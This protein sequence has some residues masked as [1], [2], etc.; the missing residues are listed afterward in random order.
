MAYPDSPAFE[1]VAAR[2][3][4]A[5]PDQFRGVRLSAYSATTLKAAVPPTFRPFY[6][7]NNP[8]LLKERFDSPWYYDSTYSEAPF[9]S[10]LDPW[11]VWLLQNPIWSKKTSEPST[12]PGPP[13][14]ISDFPGTWR[15]LCLRIDLSNSAYG[16]RRW[17][18]PIAPIDW[19]GAWEGYQKLSL[20]DSSKT[21]K[22]FALTRCALFIIRAR[23]W[24]LRTLTFAIKD[25][26]SVPYNLPAQFSEEL[27]ALLQA[28]RSEYVTENPAYA[29]TSL[30]RHNS[31]DEFLWLTHAGVPL[32]EKVGPAPTVKGIP[33]PKETA[34]APRDEHLRSGTAALG[35]WDMNKPVSGEWGAP[36]SGSNWNVASLPTNAHLA[37][38]NVGIP[39]S[40]SPSQSS[41]AL[42]YPPN[43]PV[44]IR[45]EP[46]NYERKQAAKAA[47]KMNPTQKA[48]K[49][50]KEAKTARRRKLAREIQE[51]RGLNWDQAYDEA[52]ADMLDE[53]L[54]LELERQDSDSEDLPLPLGPARPP[55]PDSPTHHP[56]N[57]VTSPPLPATPLLPSSSSDYPMTNA[58]PITDPIARRDDLLSP[59][60]SPMLG[61]SPTS[62]ARD[63]PASPEALPFS[64]DAANDRFI[65]ASGTGWSIYQRQGGA[66]Y[67][68]RTDGNSLT[69]YE[70][71]RVEG[72]LA[73]LS[74]G[75]HSF[76]LEDI[77]WYDT[78]E[79]TIDPPVTS[80]DNPPPLTP[81]PRQPLLNRIAVGY[82]AK[83]PLQLRISGS[84]NPTTPESVIRDVVAPSPPAGP[85]LQRVFPYLPHN[86]ITQL[87]TT[88]PEDTEWQDWLTVVETE[89]AYTT[90]IPGRGLLLS[91]W[92]HDVVRPPQ[93]FLRMRAK[94]YWVSWKTNNEKTTWDHPDWN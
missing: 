53:E 38:W 13:T 69:I 85:L 71:N 14:H 32:W 28:S 42:S 49:D 12:L 11:V 29:G 10:H 25:D 68:S 23:A 26:P 36:S 94:T 4:R 60:P 93:P 1:R 41:T 78:E 91:R 2:M 64:I 40:S 62:V 17:F 76:S 72:N 34:P 84:P 73:W 16:S 80:R 81:N 33:L 74:L 21:A 24:L 19:N 3:R 87:R 39:E 22:L 54:T 88:A 79:R 18:K 56:T 6:D 57:Q 48:K 35:G 8:S 30:T 5:I 7:H 15:D 65:G 86:F 58:E 27:L 92:W 43:P 52:G 31:D 83:L 77:Q 45:F 37:G 59:P 47:R 44:T 61:V 9:L 90:P 46:T 51:Q 20:F 75:T 50:A 66:K 63:V 82:S 70:V 55:S 67:A 89:R